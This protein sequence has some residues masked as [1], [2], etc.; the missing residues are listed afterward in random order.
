MEAMERFVIKGNQPLGGTIKVNG[1]KNAALKILAACLLTDKTLTISNVPQIEDIFRLI[2]LLKEV[3]V[4]IE[5]NS[6]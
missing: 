3:G 4:K 2:E 1:A 5:N 6:K